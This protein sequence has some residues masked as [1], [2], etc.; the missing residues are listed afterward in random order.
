MKFKFFIIILLLTSCNV[1]TLHKEKFTPYSSSGFAL[2]YNKEDYTNKTIARKLDQ[3]TMQVAHN[4]LKTN[5]I[6]RIRN[7]ENNKIITLKVKKKIKY[8]DFFN[9]LITKK[10]SDELKLD[11]NFPYVEV[12]QIIKNKSF[13]AQKA[14]T[15][16]EEQNVSNTAP[17][18]KVKISNISLN[19]ETDNK[20]I[21]QFSIII[22][23]FSSNDSATNLKN[24]LEKGYLDKGALKIAKTKNNKFRLFTGPYSSINTLKKDYFKLNKY[25]FSNLDIVK[26]DKK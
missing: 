14:V 22:G 12:E 26:N 18:T 21:K 4:K 23:D 9:L 19:K 15:F 16:T 3:N 25:G 7:P 10:V 13:V 17:V 8:P 11:E 1:S 6:V 20:R 24:I 2:I 5:T